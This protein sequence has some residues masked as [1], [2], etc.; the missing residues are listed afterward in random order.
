M[1][2]VADGAPR[3]ASEFAEFLI[4]N[5]FRQPGIFTD[6]KPILINSSKLVQDLLLKLV[7]YLMSDVGEVWVR[8]AKTVE[9]RFHRLQEGVQYRVKGLDRH[10]DFRM[11][12]MAAGIGASGNRLDF[13]LEATIVNVPSHS[14]VQGCNH[15]V[16]RMG[17]RCHGV[18]QLVGNGCVCRVAVLIPDI[19][20]RLNLYPGRAG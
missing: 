7:Q 15:R 8:C 1:D 4:E 6:S 19:R 13:C 18:I 11:N 16:Q 17:F 20:A 5:A 2:H 14:R 9:K 10:F 3:P 12:G